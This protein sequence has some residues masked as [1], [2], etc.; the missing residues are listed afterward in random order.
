MPPESKPPALTDFSPLFPGDR[1]KAPQAVELDTATAWAEFERLSAGTADAPTPK[2]AA[3]AAF[4]AT[5]VQ[6]LGSLDASFPAGAAQP[7]PDLQDA[8]VEARRGNRVCPQPAAWQRLHALL[9]HAPDG[10]R[11]PAPIDAQ[12]WQ[13]TGAMAKRL[14]LRDQIEWAEKH[15]AL[16]AV[17]AFMQALPEGEWLHMGAG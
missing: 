8:L 4:A 5:V 7:P 1:L 3:D 16:G 13:G 11:P 14:C 2:P 15:G 10:R 9:P 6:P 12:A 17:M